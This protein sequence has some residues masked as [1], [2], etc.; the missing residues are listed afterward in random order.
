MFG[1]RLS[2]IFVDLSILRR[3]GRVPKVGSV[4]GKGESNA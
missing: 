3:L 1:A 4:L 2:M